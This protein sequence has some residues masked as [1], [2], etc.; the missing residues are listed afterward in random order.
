M[1][2]AV[3]SE[4]HPRNSSSSSFVLRHVKYEY[5]FRDWAAAE[6]A[7]DSLAPYLRRLNQIR[8]EHP[9][10]RQLRGYTTQWSEDDAIL[11]YVKH[12]DAALS[13]SGAADTIIVVAN[14]DPHSARETTVHIDS[15]IW[16]LPRGVDYEVEDLVTGQTWVWNE[17]NFVRLDAFVEPVHILA[18]KE[19]S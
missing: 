7:G 4:I 19:R 18:V 13:P 14:V 3:S 15:E 11:T 8:R 2:S 10:L 5:K 1:K 12:L 16:G 17:H 9:A 6:A